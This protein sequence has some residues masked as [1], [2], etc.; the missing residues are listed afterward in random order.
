M[1]ATTELA[2]TPRRDAETDR[3]AQTDRDA[4]TDIV[5]RL[6]GTTTVAEGVLALDLR[7]DDGGHLPA[8]RPGAHIDLVL[9][10]DLI[11]QY[12]LCGQ[13]EQRDRYLTAVLLEVNGRGGS[14][15]I[16][17]ALAPGC[18][19]VARGPRN[20]FELLP[21][22]RYLFIAGGIGVTP[23]RP[24]IAA[25]EAA[26]AQWQ[27]VYGGRSR[28]SMAFCDDLVASYGDRVSICPQDEVGLLDLPGLLGE[29][30][31]DTLVYCCGPEGLLGAV[32]QQC[33]TWPSGSLRVERFA[34]KVI[35]APVST[36]AFEVELARSGQTVVVPPGRSILECVLEVG[37]DVPCS[38][39]EGTCGSCETPV[40]DGV[41]DHRD[42]VLSD[43]ERD[44][45]N[46][47]MVCCSRAVSPRLV[48]NL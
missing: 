12:S 47:M 2:P 4:E 21:A 46:T 22:R 39:Q 30:R 5:L 20:H 25:A 14:R 28:A 37:V 6:A 27:L 29:P 38:C 19:V 43:A 13:P 44:A 17:E 10:P 23:L 7:A 40:L 16:H 24:M 33:A 48:L 11:R 18:T 3:A 41:V 42:S 1:T 15:H 9:G 35:D 8:W 36:E 34:P 45:H 31:P 26:G 32:E